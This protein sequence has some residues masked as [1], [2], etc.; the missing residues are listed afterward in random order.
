MN[1]T[2]AITHGAMFQADTSGGQRRPAHEEIQKLAYELYER[3]GKQP[4]HELE[5]WVAAEKQLCLHY[6]ENLNVCAVRK[7][8]RL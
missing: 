3:R 5:D 2:D 8:R 7:E 4:G 6:W 1:Y